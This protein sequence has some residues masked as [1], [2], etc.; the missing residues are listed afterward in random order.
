M[1][2]AIWSGCAATRVV[3]ATSTGQRRPSGFRISRRATSIVEYT[4]KNGN[5]S[6]ERSRRP[7][8]VNTCVQLSYQEV[9]VPSGA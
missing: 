4:E 7:F 9:A 6:C 5:E 1:L 2:F 3:R 8:S